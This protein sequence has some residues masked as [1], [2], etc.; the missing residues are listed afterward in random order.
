VHDGSFSAALFNELKKTSLSMPSLLTLPDNELTELAQSLAEQSLKTDD[1]KNVLD[2][3]PK[4]KYKIVTSKPASLVELKTR[5]Q[6]L[7]AQKSKQN[8]IDHEVQFNPAYD[9][10]D[11]D[12]ILAVRLGKHALRDQR[13][14]TML[15][16]KFKNQNKI[17]TFLGVN[18]SSINRRCKE[19]NL[20]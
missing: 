7:L 12:L 10:S 9:T 20:E 1:F 18:R 15:W 14:M 4:D 17:A 6:Q 16:N 3:N 5:V 8:A 2:L 19:Y 13:I 11:P